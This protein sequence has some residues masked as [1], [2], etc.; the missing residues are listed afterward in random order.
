MRKI[1]YPLLLLALAVTLSSCQGFFEEYAYQPLGGGQ[2]QN[3]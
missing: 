1:F 2:Y 3:Y